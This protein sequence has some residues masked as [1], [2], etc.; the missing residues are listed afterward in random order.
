MGEKLQQ[1]GDSVRHTGMQITGFRDKIWSKSNLN[2]TPI[3]D[4]HADLED[5]IKIGEIKL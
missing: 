3:P 4:I 2:N 1:F 5:K